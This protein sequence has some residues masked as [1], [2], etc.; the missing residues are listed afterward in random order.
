[1][2]R[3]ASRTIQVGANCLIDVS[4]PPAL[5]AT[6][7]SETGEFFVNWPSGGH[8]FLTLNSWWKIFDEVY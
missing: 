8:E 3:L 4:L 6:I 1:M 5:P 7:S 2:L